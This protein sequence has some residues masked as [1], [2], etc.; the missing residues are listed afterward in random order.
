[1]FVSTDLGEFNE[2]LRAM[3]RIVDLRGDKED[4]RGLVDEEVLEILVRAVI[5]GTVDAKEQSGEFWRE[6]FRGCPTL[7]YFAKPFFAK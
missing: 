4:G 7:C 1:M 5:E 2:A 6:G 3:D